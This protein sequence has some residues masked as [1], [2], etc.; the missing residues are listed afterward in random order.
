MSP[1]MHTHFWCN[2]T[3]KVRRAKGRSSTST[4]NVLH[5]F[6][7]SVEI[8]NPSLVSPHKA[9]FDRL[10]GA[11]GVNIMWSTNQ[12]VNTTSTRV[13]F[14]CWF[15]WEEKKCFLHWRTRWVVFVLSLQWKS[16]RRWQRKGC[17][18]ER[19]KTCVRTLADSASSLDRIW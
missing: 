15:N 19:T 14:P 17:G 7:L 3:N 4:S 1:L 6:V 9:K 8:F 11:A 10:S 13:G 18:R 16:G 12:A 5:E 2:N